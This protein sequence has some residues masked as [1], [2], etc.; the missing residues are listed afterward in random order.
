MIRALVLTHGNLGAELV[1]VVELILGPV[2]GMEAMS[3]ANRSAPELQKAV[4]AWLEVGESDEGEIIMIDDYG[5]SCAS[6]ALIACGEAPRREVVSGVNLAMLLGF[7]TWR[8]RGDHEEVVQRI[9]QKG[10]EAI[11]VVGGR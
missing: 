9:V 7:V 10:R 3:N 5:G 8:E 2:P 6:A 4:A 11:T 1:R